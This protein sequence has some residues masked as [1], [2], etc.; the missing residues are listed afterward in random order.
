MN[1]IIV[2]VSIVAATLSAPAAEAQRGLV[3]NPSIM[4]GP[5][6]GCTVSS[7]I[8]DNNS[9]ALRYLTTRTET[10]YNLD[11]DACLN[12]DLQVT[13]RGLDQLADDYYTS[14]VAYVAV[15][16]RNFRHPSA[17]L[18]IHQMVFMLYPITYINGMPDIS[19]TRNEYVETFTPHPD[20]Y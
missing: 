14:I 20:S 11:K 13:A 6:S 17:A 2:L 12:R 9:M 15:E 10:F 8:F 1:R 19:P 4:P 3:W 16:Y 18:G 5:A 7:V